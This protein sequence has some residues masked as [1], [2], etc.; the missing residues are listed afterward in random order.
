MKTAP[1]DLNTLAAASIHEVKNLLGQLTLSLDSIA[2]IGCPG[3][4]ASI[5][6]ARFACRRIVDRLSEMLTLYK[7]EGGHLAP[8]IDAH[9]PIDF[10]EDLMLEA[11]TLTAGRLK[12]DLQ[13]DSAPPF[14]FF[15]RELAQSALM[16]ALHNALGFARTRITLSAAQD[17]DFL[18]FRVAD[19]GPGFPPALLNDNFDAPRASQQGTG[20]GLYFANSVAQVHQNKGRIGKVKLA[21]AGGAVFSLL[22]P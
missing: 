6:G 14:W 18:V 5:S 22:L 20:L 9:S 4:E 16:N 7:L 2:E 13:Q 3:A 19:D 12:I 10:L 8:S 1:L 21:N 11:Q 17:G 15:D